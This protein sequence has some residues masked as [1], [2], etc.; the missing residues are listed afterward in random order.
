MQTFKKTLAA[1]VAAALVVPEAAVAASAADA[2]APKAAPAVYSGAEVADDQVTLKLSETPQYNSFVTQ[3]PP[4]L[5]LELLDTKH[6]AALN[7]TNS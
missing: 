7:P 6:A 1:L 2:A 5:V 4:R 3:T